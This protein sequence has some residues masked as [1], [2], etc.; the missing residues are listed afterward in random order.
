ME[1]DTSRHDL[2]AMPYEDGILVSC[3]CGW[4]VWSR[5][6]PSPATL[7]CAEE[8]IGGTHL[9]EVNAPAPPRREVLFAL[10]AFVL[11]VCVTVLVVYLIW[12]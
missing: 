12:T 1:Q 11:M 4:E 3:T 7:R 9:A 5:T 10:G 6:G 2:T 8:Q